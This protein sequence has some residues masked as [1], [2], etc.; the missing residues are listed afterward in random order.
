MNAA[1]SFASAGDSALLVVLG[2]SLDRT[3]NEHVHAL[4][5]RLQQ[6]P[7]LREIVPAYASL[8]VHYDPEQTN[9]TAVRQLVSEQ[10][11]QLEAGAAADGRLVA[12]PVRYDGPDLDF[13]AAHTGLTREVVIELHAAV[14]YRVYM[15]GFTPGFAYLGEIDERLA[16][17]RLATPRLRV[18]AGAVGI[19][20]RQTGIYPSES[21]GGWRLLGHTPL[22]LFDLNRSQPFLLEPGDR[23]KFEPLA[24]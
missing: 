17:P 12:I 3:I 4:A 14:E 11:A 9:E 16:T 18:N 7:G 24:N 19:A 8:L 20:G 15:L 1:L 21:P 13:V 23:V 2:D 22:K 6:Q 10:A 5:A